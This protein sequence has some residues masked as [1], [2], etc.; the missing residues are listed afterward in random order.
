MKRQKQDRIAPLRNVYNTYDA[1]TRICMKNIQHYT[2]HTCTYY[3]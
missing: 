1:Y 3:I 2:Q